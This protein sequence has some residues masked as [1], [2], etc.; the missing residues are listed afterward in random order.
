MINVNTKTLMSICMH[1]YFVISLVR[2]N[3]NMGSRPFEQRYWLLHWYYIYR[4]NGYFKGRIIVLVS[5]DSNS[6]LFNC[7]DIFSIVREIYTQFVI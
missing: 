5:R 2:A 4:Y 7:N 1:D 3:N 6:S